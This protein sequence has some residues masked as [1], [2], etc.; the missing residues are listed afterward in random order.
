MSRRIASAFVW[1]AVLVAV[2]APRAV[3][4]PTAPAVSPPPPDLALL[5]PSAPSTSA[6]EV[7]PRAA[8]GV[9]AV[10]LR[11]AVRNT[12]ERSA[13][14]PSAVP[15]T[16]IGGIG[17]TASP[18]DAHGAVGPAHLVE[19]AGGVIRISTD[20]GVTLAETALLDWWKAF[21]PT[22][23]DVDDP[24][25]VWEPHGGRFAMVAR[26]HRPSSDAGLALA[27]SRTPDPMGAWWMTR[28]DVDAADLLDARSTRLGF[29]GA[30]VT[31]AADRVPVAGGAPTGSL[32]LAFDRAEAQDGDAD[33]TY[34]RVVDAARRGVVPVATMDRWV[35]AQLLAS[36]A[37]TGKGLTLGRIS[38]TAVSPVYASVAG[39]VTGT[40]WSSAPVDA[41]QAGS[42]IPID[43]GDT[44]LQ[45]CAQRHAAVWCTHTVFL[46]AAAPIRSSVQWWQF[47][48]DGTV[49]Q[50]G[51]VD[52]AEPS[53]GTVFTAYPSL[54]VNA[55]GDVMLGYARFSSD[56]HASGAVR[57]R[58]AADPVGTMRDEVVVAAGEAPYLAP[59]GGGAARWGDTS[60]TVADPDGPLWT[61]QTSAATP[62]GDQHRWAT[63]WA[64]IVPPAAVGADVAVAVA[65]AP[66]AALV[67]HRAWLDL[68]AVPNG[69]A[70]PDAVTLHLDTPSG[71]KVVSAP[72]LCTVRAGGV[73]CPIG[74]VDLGEVTSL[75]VA[76]ELSVVGGVTLTASITSADD[77]NPSNDLRRVVVKGLDATTCTIS[78]TPGNDQLVG[79]PGTDVLCGRG[80]DDVIYPSGGE[81]L[82]IGGAGFDYVAYTDV[83]VGVTVN[84]GASRAFVGGARSDLRELEGA[85]GGAGPDTLI[86]GPGNDV[87][88]G[89][90]GNDVIDGGPGVDTVSYYSCVGSGCTKLGVVVSLLTGAG[91]GSGVGTDS[92]RR[93]ERVYGSLLGNDRL[94]GNDGPNALYGFGGNDELYG[95]G[96]ADLL[97]GGDGAD[98]LGGGAGDDHLSGGAGTDV[99]QGGSGATTTD[100]CP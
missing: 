61:L 39:T 52:D 26:V 17:G 100:S 19:T 37:G 25:V 73:D 62:S 32:V 8:T 11:V 58:S 76:V 93:I 49:L 87:L 13:D 86:G 97:Y 46:P 31:V 72:G 34:V 10:P 55:A 85:F 35:G 24:A 88:T 89:L 43:T 92:L 59:A 57:F 95:N 53:D 1:A 79:T 81:D 68:V 56:T 23:D 20:A 63:T 48:P 70:G 36:A 67:G 50:Q 4:E 2:A 91:R 77:P 54:A 45:T 78:G 82:V 90:G 42:A 84:L 40:A 69:P 3:A 66:T 29:T 75:A 27:V 83:G 65:D 41:P 74:D 60:A 44:R 7:R 99:C 28:V 6:V 22:I 38:G 16:T 21:D 12:T 96:G 51:R 9:A 18:P 64:R 94:S 71:A 47:L 14:A 33:M 80:G 30:W 15:S 5:A 98:R